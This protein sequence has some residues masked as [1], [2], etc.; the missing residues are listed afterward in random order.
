MA[1]FHRCWPWLLFGVG[2]CSPAWRES[3]SGYE[4]IGQIYGDSS[5]EQG[6]TICGVARTRTG[7][8]ALPQD[9]KLTCRP[10][11]YD[12]STEMLHRYSDRPFIAWEG[13]MEDL[14]PYAGA[15]APKVRA[16]DQMVVAL[17]PTRGVSIQPLIGERTLGERIEIHWLPDSPLVD[18]EV[19]DA[20]AWTLDANGELSGIDLTRVAGE[21][22]R[23]TVLSGPGG[24]L[25]LGVHDGR[26]AV[27][28]GNAAQILD[29]SDP[30]DPVRVGVSPSDVTEYFTQIALRNDH[31]YL[32][33]NSQ[34]IHTLC[35]ENP[36]EPEFVGRPVETDQG[37]IVEITDQYLFQ[38][39]GFDRPL[40]V[41]SLRNP[42]RPDPF[43]GFIGGNGVFDAT[44]VGSVLYLAVGSGGIHLWG[45]RRDYETAIEEAVPPEPL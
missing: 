29:A 41:A 42:H 27:L 14:D 39:P 18:L 19:E 5:V 23:H 28:A 1:A 2:G 22:T 4:F 17:Q 34:Q 43:Q 31:V 11:D 33:D 45:P 38:A 36:S 12:G 24:A 20:W 15:P 6:P 9:T 21:P 32:V 3:L 30:E 8:H 35:L 40:A 26:I 25:D 13:S 10:S 37:P 44:F 16:W 7:L